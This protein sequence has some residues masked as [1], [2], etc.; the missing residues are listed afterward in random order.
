MPGPNFPSTVF[1]FTQ[2]VILA[3]PNLITPRKYKPQP[4]KEQGEPKF[5]AVLLVK[6]DHPELGAIYNDIVK[7][8]EQIQGA[9]TRNADGSV[10]LNPMCKWPFK[11]GDTY[12]NEPP[13][14][15]QPRKRSR[16]PFRG[17]WMFNVGTSEQRPPALSIV[18]N[19]GIRDLPRDNTISAYVKTHFFGGALVLAKLGIK[20]FAGN[21]GA[22]VTIYLNTVLGLGQG[23]EIAEFA[24][25]G[26]DGN[27]P[28]SAVWGSSFAGHVGHAT[29]VN[30]TLV[31][32]AD[33][34]APYPGQSAGTPIAP[35]MP[36]PGGPQ[37]RY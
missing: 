15:G 4:G 10:A 36:A 19:N 24:G 32:P 37:V 30:P 2:P 28:G 14:D 26:G 5:Q 11:L 3:M 33:A 21:L 35:M 20:A 27:Q 13:K 34:R 7:A 22:G 17:Y 6:P 8:G 25:G 16:D 29:Q 9:V 1:I 18:E 23:Q 12:A 31:N